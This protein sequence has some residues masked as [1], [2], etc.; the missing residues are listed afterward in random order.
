M[1]LSKKRKKRAMKY[2]LAISVFLLPLMGCPPSDVVPNKN[3]YGIFS[4][5]DTNTISMNGVIGNKTPVHFDNIIA[6]NPSTTLIIMKD[7][8]GSEDDESNIKVALEMHKKGLNTH[9]EKTSVI[10]SGAVDFFLAGIQRSGEDGAQIG[11]HSWSDGKKQATDFPIG[12]ANHDLYINYYVSTGF[13]K[14]Q[15]EDFYYFTINSASAEGVHWMTSDEINTY[16]IFT[17]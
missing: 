17:K 13:T 15:S 6:A 9:L 2:I 11:V 1:K 5:V 4:I 16:K 14:K 3:D 10:A 8:P 7:C 12:H